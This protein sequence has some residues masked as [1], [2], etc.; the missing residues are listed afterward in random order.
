MT[1]RIGDLDFI[2]LI[3]KCN[4]KATKKQ[5]LFTQDKSG[6]YLQNYLDRVS[7]KICK[8]YTSGKRISLLSLRCRIFKENLLQGYQG[9]GI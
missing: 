1:L 2:G 9:G 7:F 5:P 6:N 4:N 8:H 3:V